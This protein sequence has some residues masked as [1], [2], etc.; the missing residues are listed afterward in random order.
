MANNINNTNVFSPLMG[1]SNG[2]AGY[3]S[4][5]N[6]KFSVDPKVLSRMIYL[7]ADQ[8][9]TY[10]G[11]QANLEPS[12]TDS[13]ERANRT[14]FIPATDTFPEGRYV[15]EVKEGKPH[16]RGVATYKRHP[17]R[18]NWKRYEGDWENGQF[19]GLGLLT[20]RNGS[21]YDGQW[22][23]GLLHGR[24]TTFEATRYEKRYEGEF[25]YGKKQGYGRETYV[26]GEFLVYEG[27]WQE[28]K[29]HGPGRL[30][31]VFGDTYEGNF[32][33]SM[34]AGRGTI[35]WE[36][37]DVYE[38]EC[39]SKQEEN[40]SGCWLINFRKFMRG[41]GTLR[42]KDRVL[43]GFW[44]DGALWSGTMST[45]YAQYTVIEGD[46]WLGNRKVPELETMYTCFPCSIL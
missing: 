46:R 44:R 21:T 15:G 38:G 10:L 6:T 16:G 8:I 37:G 1:T 5:D 14:I 26:N 32:E 22:Q 4:S 42:E 35:T 31:N 12:G 28:D 27:N 34:V 3:G 19:H 9:Q 13:T 17:E 43:T 23:S 39:S 29:F 20:L 41:E 11:S 40:L 33:E 25:A 2:N 45:N 30:V 36:N 18:K 24:A 7:R